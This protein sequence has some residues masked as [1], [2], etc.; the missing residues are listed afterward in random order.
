[1]APGSS[2][3][4]RTATP[5]VPALTLPSAAGLPSPANSQTRVR[6]S[7]YAEQI[8]ASASIRGSLGPQRGDIGQAVL[9]QSCRERDI[10]Q[11]LARAV[12]RPRLAPGRQRCRYRAPSWP[13]LRTTSIS[14]T[15]LAVDT[16]GFPGRV[17]GPSGPG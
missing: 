6:T 11:D 15:T 5:S 9:A 7:A 10:Q 2:E 14:S 8:A 16:T 12:H 3:C 1:M 13:D 4:A 17:P